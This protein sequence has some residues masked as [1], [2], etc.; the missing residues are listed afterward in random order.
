MTHQTPNAGPLLMNVVSGK[1]GTG[2][3]LLSAVL[4]RLLAQEG[5]KVLLVDLDVFV[6]G[7]TYF[8]YT[9]RQERR[10]LTDGWVIADVLSVRHQ[11][12]DETA[13]KDAGI[14][15][16]FEVDL[17]PAVADIE[18]Q[19]VFTLDE[20]QLEN[21]T[22]LFEDLRQGK[23]GEFDYIIVDNRAGVDDLILH[24]SRHADLTIAVAE[25]DPIAR[26]TNSNLLRHL[27]DGVA[28]KI[29][30]IINKVKFLRTARDYE[31]AMEALRGDFD[32]LGQIPFDLDLFE[33]F[34]TR[35]F[36]SSVST[37]TYAFGLAEA[38]NKLAK[39]EAL[40]HHIDMS[41]FR[42]LRIWPGGNRVPTFL[43]QVERF[44]IIAGIVS[45]LAYIFLQVA[46]SDNF[47]VNL[48]LLL[49]G[50]GFLLV[51]LVRRTFR[52]PPRDERP[53]LGDT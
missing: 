35:A 32:I 15:R 52:A 33:A 4:G 25:S 11:D 13:Q 37:T 3:S 24:C 20:R 49:Y 38:W 34:G 7:L 9:F 48:I 8:F 5:A 27:R 53:P 51:P 46:G 44:S 17:I 21:V 19:L 1:G 40:A 42:R 10:V 50:I 16:F 30:T 28:R 43:A 26:N 39:R 47:D 45:I 22:G 14:T 18:E 41:R 31:R 2:K 29:Y 12:N 23:F 6:R 36:W